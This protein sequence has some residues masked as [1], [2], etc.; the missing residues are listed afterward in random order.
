MQ[1]PIRKPGLHTHDKPDPYLTEEKFLQLKNKLEKLKNFSRPSAAIEMKQH[2]SDGDFSENAA[3]QTAKGRLRGINQRILDIEEHLKN[4][5]IINP[6][7]SSGRI[8]IGNTVTVLVSGKEKTYTILGSTE[9][10]PSKGIISQ[11][12]P[13]GRALIEKKVGDRALV[14]LADRNVEYKILTI[15]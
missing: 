5:I 14:K 9:T 11:N 6:H 3:Y 15:K 13:I 12:S 4:A 8:E 1:V 7:S 10:D 2:A